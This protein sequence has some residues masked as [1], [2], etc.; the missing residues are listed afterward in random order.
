[1]KVQ[2]LLNLAIKLLALLQLALRRRMPR[3]IPPHL[4]QHIHRNALELQAQIEKRV[5]IA[6]ILLADQAQE[7][8]HGTDAVQVGV[9]GLVGRVVEDAAKERD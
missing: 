8:E 1:M 4:L 7:T 5:G 3:L 2:L 9:R 6:I